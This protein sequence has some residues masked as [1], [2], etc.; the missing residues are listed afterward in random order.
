MSDG[1]IL[2]YTELF[3]ALLNEH[4][5][6]S[7]NDET[8]KNLNFVFLG[9]EAFSLKE[10]F[11]KP[12]SQR[13]LDHDRRIFNYR[14]S[15]ARNVVENVFGI[16]T[17]RFRILHTPINM[18]IGKIK[19][20]ILAICALHNFLRRRSKG[21]ITVTALD[22]EDLVDC[23]LHEGDWRKGLQS[24][25]SR[26]PSIRAKDNREAYK[27]YFVSEGSVPWQEDMLRAGRA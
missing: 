4:L 12:Y 6:L 20:I 19:Y 25:V 13:E 10:K 26:N 24:A 17:L 21:Y 7:N 27:K 1:G 16:I 9:D 2:E 5:N 3:H 23:T 22:M 8:I 15:R 18:K 11:L 14:L